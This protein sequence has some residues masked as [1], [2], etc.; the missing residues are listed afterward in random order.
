MPTA[1]Q[2]RVPS[3]LS[4]A[5]DADTPGAFDGA[6][7]AGRATMRY[8]HRTMANILFSE[9]GAGDG[10]IEN[11]HAPAPGSIDVFGDSMLYVNTD[12]VHLV[13]RVHRLLPARRVPRRS[14]LFR[15]TRPGPIGSVSE[16]FGAEATFTA[17]GCI[18]RAWSVAEL[19]R[20]TASCCYAEK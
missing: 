12:G 20:A 10:L 8:S 2:P 1:S 3:P 16:V 9:V 4:A 5:T 18:A 13:H 11:S 15:G 7:N 14:D 19:I 6:S 17:R